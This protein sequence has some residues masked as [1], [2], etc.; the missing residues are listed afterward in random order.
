[1][2][3]LKGKDLWKAIAVGVATA[4]ILSV[5]SVTGMK[6]GISPMPKPLALA[7]AETIFSR[8]LPLPVGLAFHVAWVTF[9]SVVY[10]AMYRHTMTFS[11]ALAL[12]FVLWLSTLVVFFPIV[13][14]GFFGLNVSPMLM[15]GSAV[16]HLLFAVI[17]WGLGR[18]TFHHELADLRGTQRY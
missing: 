7:F 13:G 1:M 18:L 5:I 11:R 10:V 17:L 6:T 12:A 3:A 9:F 8:K 2:Q 15:A 16:M 14:W 4:L